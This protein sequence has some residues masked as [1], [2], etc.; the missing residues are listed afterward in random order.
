MILF[1]YFAVFCC[2]NFLV[3]CSEA[4]SYKELNDFKSFLLLKKLD[5]Q[6]EK[7]YAA[8]RNNFTKKFLKNEMK[9]D[10]EGGTQSLG[11][12]TAI[13]AQGNLM[14]DEVRTLINNSGPEEDP[15]IQFGRLAFL[16]AVMNRADL[17]TAKS[18]KRVCTIDGLLDGESNANLCGSYGE[19]L[20]KL[21]ELRLGIVTS[22]ILYSNGVLGIPRGWY[23]HVQEIIRGLQANEMLS[24][25][26]KFLLTLLRSVANN[27]EEI[28]T[29]MMPKVLSPKSFFNSVPSSQQGGIGTASQPVSA[30]ITV[31]A[32]NLTRQLTETFRQNQ[33]QQQPT[34][35][36]STLSGLL[37]GM[38]VL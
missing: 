22:R 29:G 12:G 17:A 11:I 20:V 34:Q 14:M 3:N 8:F 36:D 1:A 5:A 26:L 15:Q 28:D 27:S 35:L 9:N 21:I 6:S 19:Y 2:T 13:K 4:A 37:P 31:D 38:L 25:S 7:T 23:A 24:D 10:P 30:K 33:N 18:L 32:T 16:Y